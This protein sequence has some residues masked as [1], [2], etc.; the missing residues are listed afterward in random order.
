MKLYDKVYVESSDPDSGFALYEVQPPGL[1]R[2]YSGRL[3]KKENQV[4]MTI[5]EAIEMWSAAERRDRWFFE[6]EEFEKQNLPDPPDFT[7]YLTS[8]GINL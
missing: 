6:R 4:C 8:K 2:D 3:K 1:G 5:E 7:Q